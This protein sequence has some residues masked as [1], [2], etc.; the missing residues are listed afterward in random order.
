MNRITLLAAALG[1]VLASWASADDYHD[2]KKDEYQIPGHPYKSAQ[3][4]QRIAPV[5]K[6]DRRCDIPLLGFRNFA[7]PTITVQSGGI[8]GFG[9]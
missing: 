3:N 9:I 1:A 8:G 2:L 4:C 7:D 6:F 5:G